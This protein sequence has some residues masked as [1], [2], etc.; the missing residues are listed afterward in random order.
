MTKLDKRASMKFQN[1][2]V[3]K[4]QND[5]LPQVAGLFWHLMN[6]KQSRLLQFWGT[7]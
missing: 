7:W 6:V 3:S 5:D 2:I 1:I 4:E